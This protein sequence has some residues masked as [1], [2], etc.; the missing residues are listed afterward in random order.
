MD[1]TGIFSEAFWYI[2]PILVTMTTFLAGLFNQGVV[3]KFVPEQHRGWLKQLVS[4]VFGAGLSVAAWGLKVITFGNPVWLGVVALCVVVGLSSNGVYDI[5]FIRNWIDK[6]FKPAALL[7]AEKET[8]ETVEKDF[9]DLV[10][11][12]KP[13]EEKP[14]KVK[15]SKK[16]KSETTKE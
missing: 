8:V 10:A 3:E 15:Q 11:E 4:W 9:I 1:I 12:N 13:V 14:L 7:F 2:A 5:Q 6:W 16:T